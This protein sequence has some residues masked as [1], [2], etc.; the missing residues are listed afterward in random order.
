MAFTNE[1]AMPSSEDVADCEPDNHAPRYHDISDASRDRIYAKREGDVHNDVPESLLIERSS[2]IDIITPVPTGGLQR[3]YSPKSQVR[4]SASKRTP[5]NPQVP[6]A[7]SPI[8]SSP[9]YSSVHRE[10]ALWFWA[11]ITNVD[12]FLN[13]VYYYYRGAGFWCIACSRILHLCETSFMVMIAT[14]VLQCIDYSKLRASQSLQQVTIPNC[15][16]QMS[17]SWSIS[18]WMYIFYMIWRCFQFAVD[19]GRLTQMRSFFNYLLEIPEQD[20]QTISWQDIVARIMSIRNLNPHTAN[21]LTFK[22]QKFLGHKSK[23]RLDAHDIANRLMR[24]NN[25]LIAMINKDVLEFSLPI[26]FCRDKSFF[27]PTLEWL[28]Q[29]SILDYIFNNEGQVQQDFLKSDCRRS[30]SAK[31]RRRFIFAGL[32]NLLLAP[33]VMSYTVIR[34]VFEY[35]QEYQRN[36]SLLGARRYTPLAQWKFREFNELEHLFDERTR[37]SYPFALKYVTQFPKQLTEQFARTIL[38]ITGAL[39]AILAAFAIKDAEFFNFEI[40]PGRTSLFY[41]TMLGGVWATARGS[42]SE[43]TDVFDPECAMSNVIQH[44]RYLPE[45]WKGRL[46]GADVLREFSALYKL[47]WVLLLEELLGSITAPCVMLFSFASCSD[48]IVDFFREFTIH[49]DGLGYVCSFAVFDFHD[50]IKDT[51]AQNDTGDIRQEYYTT[52]HGKLAASFYGFLDNYGLNPGTRGKHDHQHVQHLSPLEY[53]R[54]VLGKVAA[55]RNQSSCRNPSPREVELSNH[56]AANVTSFS[57]CSRDAAMIIGNQPEQS[58][59]QYVLPE[60]SVLLDKE[61]Q[62]STTVRALYQ[63]RLL[64]KITRNHETK[65]LSFSQLRMGPCDLSTDRAEHAQIVNALG[66]SAWETSPPGSAKAG[67]FDTAT[68]ANSDT[69]V[70]GLIYQLQRTRRV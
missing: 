55:P 20:M 67:E 33:F 43:E 65:P 39:V 31:L 10:E 61:H 37:N 47:K 29:Y 36:P 45:H 6:C 16:A 3:R 53:D 21:N 19:Y 42:V 69:G 30:L 13:E 9:P 44:T 2:N 51:P 60:A 17:L 4:F 46:H 66:E 22:V 28:I 64:G 38:F 54:H 57:P 56:Y 68:E 32:L 49:V 63:E 1:W 52:K 70:L 62:P 11:N 40:T 14:F 50:G 5:R 58:S 26:P 23:Q 7:V 59:H 12:R 41:I 34:W 15:T 8:V 24:K 48:Q 35:Y 18:I 27:S 25:Y